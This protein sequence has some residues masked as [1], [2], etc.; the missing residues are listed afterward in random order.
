M[1]FN[2]HITDELENFFEIY[3]SSCVQQ[4]DGQSDIPYFQVR[5]DPNV[6]QTIY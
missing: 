1:N 5:Q 2:E 3:F 6:V 4:I